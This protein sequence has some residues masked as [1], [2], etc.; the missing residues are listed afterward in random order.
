MK[1]SLLFLSI[2]AIS[3]M[4]SAQDVAV[5]ATSESLE[6]AGIQKEKTDIEGDV[7]FAEVEG[8]GT[9]ATA[10]KDSWGTT[11][12][13]GTYRNIK[14]NDLEITLGSGVVGNANPTFESYE[15]G[16]PSAG[17]VFKMHADKDGYMTIFVKMNPNKQY[18]VFEDLDGA[19][20]YTLGYSNG[21]TTFHYNFP[22]YT[23]DNVALKQF[24]GFIDFNAPDANKYFETATKQSK[25]EEGLLLWQN[26]VTGDIVAAAKNP[27][28]KDDPDQ[29]YS[30][31]ME[32]IPGQHKPKFPWQAAGLEAN[33]GDNTGFLTFAV[34]EDTDYY[35]SALGSKA[36]CAGFVYTETFP[37]ITY[38]AIVDGDGNVTSPEVV[39][40]AMGFGAS[41]DAVETIGV[42][43][44][45]APIYNA[46]GIR[47]NAD[48][49]GLLIQN[50]K[51]FIRK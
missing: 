50:G 2:A 25:N 39:F 5:F 32:E 44:V 21:T 31:V 8:I 6:A 49:K 17:A 37:T 36:G 33:P 11:N 15:A 30:G 28:V 9:A 18:V 19:V 35:F 16:A 14:V 41:S 46:Q 3:G 26:K 24:E 51:K 40:P 38:N 48:A 27:T 45:D 22:Y 20:A 7:V 12:A 13:Y 29:Q 34:Y 23:E 10:Y 43:T 1:K 42:A 47:V 4:A